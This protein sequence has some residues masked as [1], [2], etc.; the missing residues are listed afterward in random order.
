M[1]ETQNDA[2][3]PLTTSSTHSGRTTKGHRVQGPRIARLCSPST[4]FL[5]SMDAYPHQ[6]RNESR[7]ARPHT[8][9][10]YQRQGLCD[11]SDDAQ[12]VF[13]SHVRAERDSGACVDSE[14]AAKVI[15]G[16]SSGRIEVIQNRIIEANRV[17]KSPP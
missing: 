3:G 11:P 16:V 9:R 1:A 2:G 6:Q 12:L 17:S 14:V 5:P 4:S 8:K 13:S 10:R 15:T 7:S